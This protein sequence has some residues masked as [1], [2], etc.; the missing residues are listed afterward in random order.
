MAIKISNKQVQYNDII[1]FLILIPFINALNYY[2]TYTN[3]PFN[4]H[5]LITFLIDTFD[6]YAAWWGLRSVVIFLDKKMPYEVNP[7][8]RILAQLFSTSAVG[9]L[10]IIILTEIIN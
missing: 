9:L 6:G 10:I 2:L 5:T 7:L 3:I 4:S 1:L 8:K